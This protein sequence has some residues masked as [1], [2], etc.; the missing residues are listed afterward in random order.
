M[1]LTPLE[2]LAMGTRSG[3]ID[4][5]IVKF[6]S[7][8]AGMSVDEVDSMLNK[9]SGVLGISGLSN[10][11]RDLEEA[12]GTNKRAALALDIFY[13][14]V[15]LAIGS[16]SAAMG[17]IDAIVFTAGIGE[18]SAIGRKRILEGLSFLGVEIDD[19]KNAVRGQEI[20]IS[21]EGAKVRVLVIPTNEEL[22]IAL[23]TK[24]AAAL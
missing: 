6:L 22:M 2:G 4:P 17:G 11:F 9:K 18:N 8:N 20:D 5:A 15:R 1:G 23:D 10:D 19:E 21:T 16:Y 3:S 12:Q 13:Y 24:A 14:R 7:D